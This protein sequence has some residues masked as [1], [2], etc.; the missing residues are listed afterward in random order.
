[1]KREKT[2]PRDHLDCAICLCISE[3]GAGAAPL[4]VRKV[5]FIR[6]IQRTLALRSVACQSLDRSV[7]SIVGGGALI[8]STVSFTAV[9]L[10]SRRR[11]LPPAWIS[12]LHTLDMAALPVVRLSPYCD[13]RFYHSVLS[14]E[15][16]REHILHLRDDNPGEPDSVFVS[17]AGRT[18]LQS[19]C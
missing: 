16:L 3:T 2:R 6:P 18:I 15:H 10:L 11:Y 17:P 5:V 1:M 8:F 13:A 9:P 14:H 19:E 7:L 4:D 12:P